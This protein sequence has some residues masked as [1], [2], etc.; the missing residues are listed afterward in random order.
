MMAGRKTQKTRQDIGR[1]Q[2]AKRD[3]RGMTDGPCPSRGPHNADCICHG[4][5]K[6][7]VKA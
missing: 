6:V 2:P 1:G 7:K 3:Q 5:G 4:T